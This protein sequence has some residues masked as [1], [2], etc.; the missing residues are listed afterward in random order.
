MRKTQALLKRMG[1][2]PSGSELGLITA[3]GEGEQ[4]FMV[5]RYIDAGYVKDD[6]AANWD[7]DALMTS[8]KEG[9]EEDNKIARRRGFD[10]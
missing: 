9:T 3:T 6:K 1:N 5:V 10:R 7:A 8:I 4:W 2:F